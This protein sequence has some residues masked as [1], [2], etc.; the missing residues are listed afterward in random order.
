MFPRLY[1][2]RQKFAVLFGILCNEQSP[3]T[4]DLGVLCVVCC[5]DGQ[6]ALFC[7]VL[8]NLPVYQDLN[9]IIV[10]TNCP[11]VTVSLI[12]GNKMPTRCNR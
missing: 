2:L 11:E 10:A 1:I 7:K 9:V 6:Q 12:C 5:M 4:S 8:F 3:E